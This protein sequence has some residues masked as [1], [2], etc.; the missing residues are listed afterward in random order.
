MPRAATSVHTSTSTLPL[1]NARSACSRAPWPRSPCTAPEAKP[2]FSS[3][4]ATSAAVRFVRQKIIASPRVSAWRMRETSSGLSSEWARK[5]CCV[6]FATVAPSSSGAVAL[7]WVG[8]DMYRRARLI[9]APGMV[10]ENS[11]VCRF[12][13]SMPMI[14]STSGRK[15]RSSI[16][17]ASS[18]TRVRTSRRLIFFCPARSSS[19]PGVPTTTSTPF[20][21]ASTCGSYARPP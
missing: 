2:R 3:C 14:F 15:P 1:R 20:L 17:S 11:I 12:T 8:C 7:M 6:V 19:R 16:S 18:R 4:S 5:T 21:S 9:T 10:A 13:G